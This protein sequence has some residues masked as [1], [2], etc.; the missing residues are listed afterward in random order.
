MD[1]CL[2]TPGTIY[3]LTFSVSVTGF[4]SLMSGNTPPPS[5]DTAV[6]ALSSVRLSLGAILIGSGIGLTYVLGLS[7]V[8]DFYSRNF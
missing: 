4:S 3:G 7:E 6:V 1:R 2:Q 8:V 5:G